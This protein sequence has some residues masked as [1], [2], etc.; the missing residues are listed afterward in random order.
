MSELSSTRTA[1]TASKL[2][3][4]LNE[5]ARHAPAL[6]R[7]R[8]RVEQ[9]LR[10]LLDDNGVQTHFVASRAKTAESLKKKIARPDKTYEQLWDVTDLVGVRVATYFEDAI[11]RRRRAGHLQGGAPREPLSA[12]RLPGGREAR[13]SGSE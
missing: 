8:E 3:L 10:A 9:R 12:A 4:I 11:V 5:H 13:A 7:A 6:E 1:K 2:E